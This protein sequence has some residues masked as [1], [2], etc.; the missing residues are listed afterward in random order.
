MIGCVEDSCRGADHGKDILPVVMQLLHSWRRGEGGGGRGEV[1]ISISCSDFSGGRG[2]V[3][4]RQ[5]CLRD[6][7][8]S[9]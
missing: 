9:F 5:L 6:D 8:Y 4:L 7:C 1:N 2:A 3:L